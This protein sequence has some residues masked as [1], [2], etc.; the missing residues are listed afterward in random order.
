V[1][2]FEDKKLRVTTKEMGRWG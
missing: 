2:D 1:A